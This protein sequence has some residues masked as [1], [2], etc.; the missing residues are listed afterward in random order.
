[1]CSSD[2]NG[3]PNGA[4]FNFFWRAPVAAAGSIVLNAAGNAANGNENNT[5]DFIY[6]TNATIPVAAANG[7]A[8]SLPAN[9][10]VNG[11][12][13]AAAPA[14]VA[15]GAIVAVFGSS[16][17]AGAETFSTLFGPD[18]RLIS[19]LVGARVSVNGLPAPIFYATSGQLG[20][21]I[22]TEVTGA[23]A[24]I[25]I[26]TAGQASA[27]R[28]IA[29]DASAPGI[30]TTNSQGSGQGVI[31]NAQ[32]GI[33]AAAAGSVS[34]ATTQPARPGDDVTIFATGLG[35]TT[36]AVP[37]GARPTGL[38]RTAATPS[39]TIDGQPA[40]VTFSGL[41]SCCVGLNQIN[42]KVPTAARSGNSVPVV[43]TINGKQSN[44]V[45]M[46]VGN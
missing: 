35:Q 17:T 9:G 20:I 5:G 44:M 26:T 1:M 10:V 32:T 27:S 24:T 4:D 15:P 21:Q 3:T 43:L 19:D 36:P 16:F 37:T 7:T 46:A 34:G 6:T 25:Q 23:T 38:T 12:S 45:T 14:P 11:A 22:P 28:S 33:L 31:V 39:V 42:V 18:D 8:P 40:E 13:F 30:F 29:I 41:S 2:L